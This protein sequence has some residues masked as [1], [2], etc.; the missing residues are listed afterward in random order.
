M[1]S[2]PLRTTY[3]IGDFDA[4]WNVSHFARGFGNVLTSTALEGTSTSSSTKALS[5]SVFGVSLYQPVTPYRKVQRAIKYGV[6]FLVFTFGFYFL[7]EV[8]SRKPIHPIQYATVGIPLCL[9]FLLLV[10]FAEH[11]GFA[12]AYL[13]GTVAVMSLVALYSYRMLR[14]AK[15]ALL[16][17]GLLGAMYTFLYSLLEL[18]SYSLLAGAIGLWLLTAAFMFATRRINWYGTEETARA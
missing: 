17:T 14:S 7:V 1:S 13:V 18:E 8:V 16:I 15:H 11:I 3:P 6:L 4:T 2:Y 12:S 9:F 5:A 10:A